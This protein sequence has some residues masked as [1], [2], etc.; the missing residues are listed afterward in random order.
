VRSSPSTATLDNVIGSATLNQTFTFDAVTVDRQWYRIEWWDTGGQQ[1]FVSAYFILIDT[2]TACQQ[3]PS[4]PLTRL[5]L[6]LIFSARD[7][8]VLAALPRLGSIKGTDGTEQII[9]AAETRQPAI[10]S[11]WRSIF[12]PIG[13]WDCPPNWGQGDPRSEA[14]TWWSWQWVTWQQRG[15]IGIIDYFEVRNE[16]LF[17]GAWEVAFDLRLIEL[18]NRAGACLAMF[19]DAYG[20][21]QISE[22]VQRQPVLDAML[23]QPCAPGRYHAIGYHVYEGVAGGPWKFGR[24]RLFLA[25]LPAR[26]RRLPW[27]ATEYSVGDGRGPMDCAAMWADAREA[28]AQF[29][30]EVIGFMLYSVG[31]GSEWTDISG[32]LEVWNAV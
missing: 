28:E 31:S 30:P 3:L 19:S 27:L 12:L 21:P 2:P 9:R 17:V 7:A 8:P 20:N 29:G 10:I 6:H 26:V 22:F 15:L 32:C 14:D 13:K 4:I 5:G 18:A 25:A 1:A 11:V 24:Y 23:A 16:C